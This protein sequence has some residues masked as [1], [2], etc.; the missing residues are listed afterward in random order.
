MIL[1]GFAILGAGFVAFSFVQGVI[2]YYIAFLFIFAGVGFG[3]FFPLIAAIN[4]W[5]RRNRT[6]AMAI[7]LIGIKLGALLAPLMG[8]AMDLYGWRPIAKG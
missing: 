5:F 4:H 3:G 2:G 6:K 7:G 1:I 8:R